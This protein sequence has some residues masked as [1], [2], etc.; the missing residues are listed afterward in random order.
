[1]PGPPSPARTREIGIIAGFNKGPT[2]VYAGAREFTRA[3]LLAYAP[4]N[5]RDDPR[6]LALKQFF[7][8]QRKSNDKRM[9]AGF[10]K[11]GREFRVCFNGHRL[12]SNAVCRCAPSGRTWV[13]DRSAAKPNFE[14]GGFEVVQQLLVR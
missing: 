6:R 5:T 3:S 4:A 12:L 2:R 10:T 13:P 1:M 8:P 14:R 7:K 9:L 11:A